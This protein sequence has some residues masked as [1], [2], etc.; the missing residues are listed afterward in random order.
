MMQVDNAE[1]HGVKDRL[2]V[3]H[4][5]VSAP[6]VL[7]VTPSHGF[8]L[9]VSNP[10]YIKTSEWQVLQPEVK[11][12]ESRQ[13]LDGGI[14][15]LDVVRMLLSSSLPIDATAVHAHGRVQLGSN[16]ER[17]L[18]RPAE[19]Y[20]ARRSKRNIH[21]HSGILKACGG[22]IW[23]ELDTN[24]PLYLQKQMEDAGSVGAWWDIGSKSSTACEDENEP[25]STCVKDGQQKI[26]VE[27]VVEDFAGCKRFCKLIKA[28]WQ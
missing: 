8:D 10:P 4:A 24:Q 9:I 3:M 22:T 14:D 19:K 16:E 21:S 11:V 6:D 7:T 28:G 5:C 17:K 2:D 20:A 15:G 27:A 1:S 25:I 26:E 13:A 18:G 12:W 23:M